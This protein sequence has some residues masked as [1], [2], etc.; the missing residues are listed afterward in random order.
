MLNLKSDID[1]LDIDKLKNVLSGLNSLKSKVYKLD[2]D[3]LEATPVDLSKIINVV[4]NDFVKKTEYNEL[5]KR[6]NN[7]S[8]TNTNDLVKKL[9]ITQK[10]IKLKRILLLTMIMINILQLKNFIN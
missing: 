6:V 4:K 8:T 10:L 1:K 2:S 5:V 3:K 7:I 9:I